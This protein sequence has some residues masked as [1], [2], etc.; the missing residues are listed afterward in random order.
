MATEI[1]SGTAVKVTEVEKLSPGEKLGLLPGDILL[2]IGKREPL[3]AL[4][5]PSILEEIGAEKEWITVQRD[6]IIFRV[7]T[8]GGAMGITIEP[9]PLQGEVTL[10]VKDSWTPFYSAIRLDDSLLLL[11]ERISA[12]W[13]PFPLIAYGY[14]RLWQMMGATIFMYGIGY[15]TS[16]LAF[17]IIYIASIVTLAMGGPMFLRDTAVKDGFLPRARVALAHPDDAAKL[18]MTTG[19]IL[20]L[21]RDKNKK[22]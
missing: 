16:T 5:M 3:E 20:R 21:D 10:E 4:E 11:P 2:K 8:I 15:A 18:E 9:Y 14:F 22:R 13:L 17:V 6:K 12:F 7:S 19:A 1:F